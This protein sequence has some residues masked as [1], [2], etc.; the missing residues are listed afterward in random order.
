MSMRTPSVGIVGHTG[1]LGSAIEAAL[2]RTGHPV[3]QRINSAIHDATGP[4]DV[5]ID[6]SAPAG[7]E[8]AL[9]ICTQND[10]ALIYCVS[11]ISDTDRDLLLSYGRS[12]PV[13]IAPNLSYGHWLQLQLIDL[14]ASSLAGL[15]D[16]PYVSVFE[17][18]PHTK[19]D[20]PSASAVQLAERWDAA[21][22]IPV[23]EVASYRA[24][25][26]VSGHRIDVDLD[27]ESLTI[28]H[29]V[30]ELRSAARGAALLADWAAEQVPGV[31]DSQEVFGMIFGRKP[32]DA[33]G[34]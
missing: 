27:G 1:R 33:D 15:P 8:R 29:E 24:G 14:V 25:A 9:S 26:R 10:A 23:R 31:Y 2:H 5:V 20:R 4:V 21:Y 6:A 11:S 34:Y 13:V 22:G 32:I 7:L 3:R 16:A 17:R 30:T 12:A 28:H 18:H 19:A